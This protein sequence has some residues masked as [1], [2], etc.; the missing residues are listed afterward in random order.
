[1]N[2]DIGSNNSSKGQGCEN[3]L[4]DKEGLVV[5][6]KPK[7]EDSDYRDECSLNVPSL[8][9]KDGVVSVSEIS[10]DEPTDAVSAG[11]SSFHKN[12]GSK[13]NDQR[14]ECKSQR[15]LTLGTLTPDFIKLISL[16]EDEKAIEEDE[17]D[18]TGVSSTLNCNP[19][20]YSN[21]MESKRSS[22]IN[23][24]LCPLKEAEE[25]ATSEVLTEREPAIQICL[26]DL[27]I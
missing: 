19:C 24:Y 8:E 15:V 27:T 7:A 16:S 2:E 23:G 26:S 10:R 21:L 13:E 5:P 17:E 20:G 12:D 1:V 14:R 6:G 18:S 3:R 4:G 22:F 9:Y 11:F 25:K